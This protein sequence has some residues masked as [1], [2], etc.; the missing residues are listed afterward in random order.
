M[1]WLPL[2]VGLCVIDWEVW[3]LLMDL[4]VSVLSLGAV[5]L[6]VCLQLAMLSSTCLQHGKCQVPVL[7]I[8]SDFRLLN[9]SAV[10]KCLVV[11]FLC[12]TLKQCTMLSGHTDCASYVHSGVEYLTPFSVGHGILKIEVEC[13]LLF[14]DGLKWAL[15]FSLH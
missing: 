12:H 1:G 3:C 9:I 11:H 4:W 14:P 7:G 5:I 2:D 6:Q 8:C 13:L 15:V 10:F